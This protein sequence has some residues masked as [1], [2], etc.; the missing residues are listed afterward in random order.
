VEGSTLRIRSYEMRITT[1][2]DQLMALGTGR[3]ATWACL[4]ARVLLAR[5][6]CRIPKQLPEEHDP[7]LC[8]VE[9]SKLQKT[10]SF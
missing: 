10:R 2:A 4:I 7:T 1:C 6:R 5:N 3:K 8:Y 9:H